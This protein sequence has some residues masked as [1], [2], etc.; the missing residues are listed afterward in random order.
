MFVYDFINHAKQQGIVI[1]PGRGSAAGSFISYLLNITTINPISYGLIFERF[2]NPQ[3][4]SMPDI[5]VD[6][7]D[8][9]REEVVDYL[10]NKYSK[11]NVAHIITFQRIKVKNA[12][13][14]V[15]RVLDLKTSETD[16]VINFVSYDEISD[17]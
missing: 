7:M 4:K 9:R 1:G 16:E 2:L 3:R 5:D 8:S 17:W 13:R 12:I 11:D 15:C 10:F 14:D 6:I